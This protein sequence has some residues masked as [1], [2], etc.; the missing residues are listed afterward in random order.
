MRIWM[1][2]FIL[3]TIASCMQASGENATDGCL[4]ELFIPKFPPLARQARIDSSA[5]ITLTV[6]TGG[7]AENIEMGQLHGVFRREVDASLKRSR[8]DSRCNGKKVQFSFSFKV[9]GKPVYGPAAADVCFRPPNEFIISAPP[10]EL[11]P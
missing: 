5:V 1:I 3:F 4:I 2:W 6:G 7:R 11:V 9:E 10:S 8:F